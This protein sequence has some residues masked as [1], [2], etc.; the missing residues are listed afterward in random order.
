MFEDDD[1]PAKKNANAEIGADLSTW[2]VGDIEERIA[3]LEE[4]IERLQAEKKAKQG[5]LNAAEAFFKS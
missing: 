5:S 2:S 4:E 1:R 3:V